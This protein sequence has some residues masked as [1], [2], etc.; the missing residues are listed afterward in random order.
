MNIFT[1]ILKKIKLTKKE[2]FIYLNL[3]TCIG[4]LNDDGY[5]FDDYLKEMEKYY[6]VY[7]YDFYNLTKEFKQKNNELFNF[8]FNNDNEI[9][10]YLINV[11]QF[12]LFNFKR[13]NEINIFDMLS[14]NETEKDGC[15]NLKKLK[16]MKKF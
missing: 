8:K 3:L 13:F 15:E 2:E 1:K 14:L 5:L 7:D 12:I 4:N 11:I 6:N 16:I 10:E 9:T